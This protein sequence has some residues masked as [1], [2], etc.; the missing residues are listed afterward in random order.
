MTGMFM[1]L[2]RVLPDQYPLNADLT[3]YMDNER[4]FGRLIDL[5]VIHPRLDPLYSWAARELDKPELVDLLHDG[6]PTYVWDPT[7]TTPW[8]PPP[9]LLVRAARRVLP[10]PGVN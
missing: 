6:V 8:S 9:R 3:A 7:D 4:G 2:S 5:G 1:S 10:G